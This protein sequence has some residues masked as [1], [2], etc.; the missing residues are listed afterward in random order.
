[1]LP[2]IMLTGSATLSLP[3]QLASEMQL[4]SDVP[5]TL[6]RLPALFEPALQEHQKVLLQYFF[7]YAAVWG[8]GGCLNSSSWDKWD[9]VVRDTFG[10]TANY[11]GGSGTVF[12]FY[13]DVSADG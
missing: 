11:P 5:S 3:A 6:Y 10:G 8:I 1:M 12:D 9:K 7:A 13:L 2:N 4:A